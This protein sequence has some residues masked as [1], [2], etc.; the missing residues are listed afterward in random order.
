MS[1][2]FWGNEVYEIVFGKILEFGGQKSFGF[3]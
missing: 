1:N 3:V 2:T